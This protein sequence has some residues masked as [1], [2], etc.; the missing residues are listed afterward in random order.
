MRPLI[1]GALLAA[2]LAIGGTVGYLAQPP[3][4]EPE[5]ELVEL[6]A[7]GADDGSCEEGFVI[8]IQF[9]H[10]TLLEI[11]GVAVYT[12]ATQTLTPLT[13]WFPDYETMKEIVDA[14][15]AQECG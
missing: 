10:E 7:V 6:P 15:A 1:V 9:V 3:P 12:D 4:P 14:A 2:G 8:A 13:E 11:Q 5:V